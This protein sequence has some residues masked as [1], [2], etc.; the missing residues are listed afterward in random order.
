M[1]K[2]WITYFFIR[3]WWLIAFML[4]CFFLYEQGLK[5]REI[6]YQQ[7]NDQLHSLL[8][9]KTHALKKQ[10]NLQV[11]VNSQSD[12]HWIELTLMKG[13]GLSPEDQQKVYFLE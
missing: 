4:F 10:K 8:I 11:Q 13:L 7:L 9:E 3:S 6:R 5:K 12:P 2:K 1:G